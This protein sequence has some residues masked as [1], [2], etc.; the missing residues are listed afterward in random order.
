MMRSSTLEL[1]KRGMGTP[2][3]SLHPLRTTQ[4]RGS[5][6]CFEDACTGSTDSEK[7]L[8]IAHGARDAGI[9]PT[10]LVGPSG[11]TCSNLLIKFMGCL[12]NNLSKCLVLS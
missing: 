4:A 1:P 9:R 10:T 11:E 12:M 2:D 8:S 7:R 6:F 3:D 5:L